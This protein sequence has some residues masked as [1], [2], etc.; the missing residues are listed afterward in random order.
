MRAGHKIKSPVRVLLPLLPAVDEI[1]P[2]LRRIDAS[3]IYTNYGPLA[4]EFAARLAVLTCAPS[5]TLT[6]NGTTAIEIALRAATSGHGTCLMPSFT[7]IATAHAVC[8][9][10]LRPHLIDIDPNELVITPEIVLAALPTL[11]ERPAAVVVVSAFGAPPDVA[12]WDRFE[13]EVGVPVVFDA[14]AA[15]TALR[16]VGTG[17]V[18]ISLHATK[19][20]GIG[21]G[22]A[23]LTSDT[24]LGDRMTAMTGFGFNGS[25]RLATIRGGNYRISEYA[26]AVGLAA[27][28]KLPER[29]A[30]LQ[31]LVLRYRDGLKDRQSRLQHGVGEAW[32]TMT[33]N[34]ILPRGTVSET[35]TRLDAEGVEWRRWWGLGTH[36]HPPFANLSRSSLAVTEDVAPRVIGLPFH[37]SLTDADIDRVTALLP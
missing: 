16:G 23:I 25:P 12:A 13:A 1:V 6:C 7:F 34:V 17:P 9:A 14:A 37:V 4:T 28:D 27:I 11:S 10:G 2:Y 31:Q 29:M 8:N 35:I 24:S 18:C 32:Q 15:T 26:A 21:E 36:H 20:L 19:V 22:G 3:R 30:L 33:L 5:V